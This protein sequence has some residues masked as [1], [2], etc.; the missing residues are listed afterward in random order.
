MAQAARH[1]L[2]SKARKHVAKCVE[3][4]YVV[5]H[6]AATNKADPHDEGSFLQRWS[7]IVRTHAHRFSAFNWLPW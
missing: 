4:L 7:H 3:L 6:V 5:C 2:E 1:D